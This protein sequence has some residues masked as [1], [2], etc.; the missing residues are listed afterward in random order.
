MHRQAVPEPR[1]PLQA[2]L[3][4]PPPFAPGPMAHAH[5]GAQLWGLLAGKG[6]GGSGREGPPQ[7]HWGRSLVGAGPHIPCPGWA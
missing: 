3:G 6:M 1:S 5:L 7:A 4:F 2:S